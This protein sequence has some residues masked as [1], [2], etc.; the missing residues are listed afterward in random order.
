[1]RDPSAVASAANGG[2]AAAA[3]AGGG[4][5]V[6]PIVQGAI[7]DWDVLEACLDHVLYER[8]SC[9]AGQP[10]ATAVCCPPN[11][12]S[13]SC[14]GLRACCVLWHRLALR[15]VW[16]LPPCAGNLACRR[17]LAAAACRWGGSAA[18]RAG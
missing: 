8:V 18:R 16:G 17:C 13:G 7:A 9:A 5:V 10:P 14:L 11:C 1:M 2:Q 4:R 3:A 6:H 12:A 15:C